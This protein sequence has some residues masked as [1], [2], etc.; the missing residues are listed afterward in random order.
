[1]SRRRGI[2]THVVVVAEVALDEPDRNN[3][4]NDSE[5]ARHCPAKH[6][7]HWGP[8]KA[9][10][11][12]SPIHP[13]CVRRSRRVQDSAGQRHHTSESSGRASAY[14]MSCK[15][16]A[17]ELIMPF[18]KAPTHLERRDRRSGR[19]VGVSC[20]TAP[21]NNAHSRSSRD[22]PHAQPWLRGLSVALQV[23]QPCASCA[24]LVDREPRVQRPANSGP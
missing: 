12:S 9:T 24:T 11:G 7:R 17:Y 20:W 13:T 23:Q 4:R 15:S 1:M 14:M 6:V 16:L 19:E 18:S 8:A 10:V 2:S 21:R 5:E 3:N 22:L